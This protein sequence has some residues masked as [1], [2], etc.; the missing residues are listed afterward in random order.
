MGVLIL[1]YDVNNYD[2]DSIKYGKNIPYIDRDV[3]WISFNKRVLH[4]A[5]NKDIPLNE[6]V[7]FLAITESNLDEFISVRFA[8]VFHSRKD[9]KSP[10]QQLI[11]D[12]NKFN[13]DRDIVFRGLMNH[14]KNRGIIFAHPSSLNKKE[15]AKLDKI[16]DEN[17]FPLLSILDIDNYQFPSGTDM[18]GVMVQ[19]DS[20]EELYVKYVL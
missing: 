15:I 2:D 7:N 13:I 5:H 20:S 16:Y 1:K 3:S 6:R 10:Y 11:H 17:I 4:C 18:I 12:I 14:F 19:N 9:K 8:S